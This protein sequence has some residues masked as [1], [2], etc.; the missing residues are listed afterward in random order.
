MKSK[1]KRKRKQLLISKKHNSKSQKIINSHSEIIANII[2]NK[3]ISLTITKANNNSLSNQL[4]SFC[5]EAIKNIANDLLR[6]KYLSHDDDNN[7]HDDNNEIAS[8]DIIQPIKPTNDRSAFTLIKC[9][10]EQ[11]HRDKRKI[12]VKETRK[13]LSLNNALLMKPSLEYN[14]SPIGIKRIEAV[15]PQNDNNANKSN[16]VIIKKRY[17]AEPIELVSHDIDKSIKDYEPHNIKELRQE[18]IMYANA[19]KEFQLT[20]KKAKITLLLENSLKQPGDDTDRNN[21]DS[22]YIIIPYKKDISKLDLKE[23][24]VVPKST[25]KSIIDCQESNEEDEELNNTL[26]KS[27]QFQNKEWSTSAQNKIPQSGLGNTNTNYASRQLKKSTTL[28]NQYQIKSDVDIGIG[29]VIGGSNFE[30]INPETG[31]IVKNEDNTQKI[32]NMDFFRK[33][34]R[35]S[36]NDFENK[37]NETLSIFKSKGEQHNINNN[38]SK[39]NGNNL[40]LEKTNKGGVTFQSRNSSYSL[41]NTNNALCSSV[42]HI[43]KPFSLMRYSRMNHSLST[44]TIKLNPE[45]NGLRKTL[46]AFDSFPELSTSKAS[47]LTMKKTKDIFYRNKKSFILNPFNNKK[48]EDNNMNE[49]NKFTSSLI[50]KTNKDWGTPSNLIDISNDHT[51]FLPKKPFQ[52]SYFKNTKLKRTLMRQHFN[53]TFL[54]KDLITYNK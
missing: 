37:M 42:K 32:G 9:S 14:M 21:F 53:N 43:R 4:T 50:A 46:D 16:Q 51:L 30:M 2:I 34:N 24:F 17:K 7:I 31:V 29:R 23:E 26:R 8:D 33:Y 6:V 44:S 5:F 1:L 3:I 48:E 35:F 52:F 47:D 39:L 45:S 54:N 13:Q 40:S 22:N 15:N 12:T 49:M 18:R 28:L 41:Y 19:N 27:K 11:E 10:Y 36:L 25:C 38:I 20:Q